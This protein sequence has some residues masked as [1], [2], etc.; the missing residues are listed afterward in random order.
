MRVQQPAKL[1][2]KRPRIHAWTAL[3]VVLVVAFLLYISQPLLAN[4]AGWLRA[5]A[6]SLFS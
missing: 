2:F 3:E 6:Q 4:A 1:R 5:L